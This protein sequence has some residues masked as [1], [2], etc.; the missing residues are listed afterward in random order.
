MADL[1]NK[2][3]KCNKVNAEAYILYMIIDSYFAK[4][5]GTGLVSRYKTDYN[6]MSE[7]ARIQA[8]L[9][10]IRKI[11][12]IFGNRLDD[13]AVL[14]YELKAVRMDGGIFL[15]FRTGFEEIVCYV[16]DSGKPVSIYEVYNYSETEFHFDIWFCYHFKN[17]NACSGIISYEQYMELYHTIK[18]YG[19]M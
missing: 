3:M 5:V 1:S 15:W 16:D 19:I 17:F 13:I 6:L 12:K 9:R 7:Q 10:V 11:E 18:L 14:D 2:K 4:G 8:E